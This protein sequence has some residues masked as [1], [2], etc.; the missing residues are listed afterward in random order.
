MA[1]PVNAQGQYNSATPVL[2]NQD[3]IPLQLDSAGNL[4][5][6]TAVGGGGGGVVTQPTGSNL[7]TVTDAGSVTN[8]TL[9]AETTK[10][11]GTVNVA[12]AQTIAVTQPTGTNLHTVIDSGS[13][14]VSGTIPV[15]EASIDSII[16]SDGVVSNGKSIIVG[17]ETNDGTPASEPLPLGTAGRSVIVE[18]VSGGT[19]IQTIVQ[20]LAGAAAS[21][22][23]DNEFKAAIDPSPLFV[24]VFD[25]PLDTTDRWTVAGLTIPTSAL[26]TLTV[27]AGTAALAVSSLTSKPTFPLL[28]VM[29]N[30]FHSVLQ[31]DPTLKTGNYRFFGLG[32]AASAPTLSAPVT[33]GVG[34][35]LLDT[36]GVLQ[37]CVWSGGVKIQSLSLASVQ[38]LDAN[39]HRYSFYYKTSIIYFEIDNVSVGNIALPNPNTSN[40]PVLALSVNGAGTVSPAA[41]FAATTLGV[42]D[43][44]HNNQFISDGQFFWRK[45]TVKA[46]STDATATDPA[47]VVAL[48][49]NSIGQVVSKVD[50]SNMEYLLSQILI[51]LRYITGVLTQG[52]NVNDESQIFR[53]DPTILQ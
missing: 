47:L 25:G 21:V 3:S 1:N 52:L 12:A 31:F 13:V 10:V 50:Q 35:E 42:A 45:A 44:A 7:H 37:G 34:F 20:G 51:E 9:S 49:P 17:G 40:L 22:R 36:T 11:I 24:D 6:N 43:S 53:N 8:A 14:T 23:P 39:F 16:V 19:A 4:L 30:Y 48:S 38:P 27:S 28:G 32:N 18:G 26:G 2:K 33:D 15:T 41:L 29:Y 5:V 46:P